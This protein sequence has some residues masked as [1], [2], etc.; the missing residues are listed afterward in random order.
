MVE[1]QVEE[2]GYAAITQWS[3]DRGDA[4]VEITYYPNSDSSYELRIVGGENHREGMY[5]IRSEA[6]GAAVEFMK[7]NV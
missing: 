2:N 6:R 5:Q 3:S 4:F 7:L 1:R